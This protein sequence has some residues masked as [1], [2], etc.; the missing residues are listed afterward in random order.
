[1]TF[2]RATLRAALAAV[3]PYSVLERAPAL[4]GTR[5]MTKA[6]LNAALR[7]TP[8]TMVNVGACDGVLFDDMTPW[9]KRIPGA[10]AVLVEPVPYNREKLRANYPDESRFVIEPVAIMREPG[11]L[12]IRTFDVD[13]L[14]SGK[15]PQEFVGCSSATDTNLIQGKGAWCQEDE[16]FA[17]FEP[18]F[19]DLEVETDTFDAVMERNGVRDIDALLIDCEGADWIVLEQV[20]LERYRPRMIKIEVGSLNAVDIGNIVVKLGI[21]GYSVG[22]YQEDIWAFL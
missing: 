20:D 4:A 13:A 22:L 14:E 8:F 17:R 1:M 5:F 2:I 21:A 18:Y 7:K 16:N 10:R 11:R 3:L 9:L 15:L 19:K 6:A 12:N